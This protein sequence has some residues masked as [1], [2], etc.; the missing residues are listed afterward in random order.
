MNKDRQNL[1]VVLHPIVS[2]RGSEKAFRTVKTR[3]RG[4]FV[5]LD[6]AVVAGEAGWADT[7]VPGRRGIQCVRALG[8]QTSPAVIARTQTGNAR[9]HRTPGRSTALAEAAF[10]TGRTPAS[11]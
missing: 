1:L 4:T 3:L 9:S 8:H 11:L 7:P 2:D 6:I 10:V 5:Q